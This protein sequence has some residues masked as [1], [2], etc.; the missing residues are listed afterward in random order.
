LIK[1]VGSN[2]AVLEK[3]KKAMKVVIIN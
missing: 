1:E 2:R 3:D